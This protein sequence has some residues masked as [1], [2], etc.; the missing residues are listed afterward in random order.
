MQRHPMKHPGDRD[1]G[2]GPSDQPTQVNRDTVQRML[3]RGYSRAAVARELGL[4]HRHLREI[5]GA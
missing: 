3:D 1:A 5:L 4:S 2:E